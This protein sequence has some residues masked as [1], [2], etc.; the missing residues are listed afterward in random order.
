[1]LTSV[2]GEGGTGKVQ[3]AINADNATKA[4][5]ATNAT[6]LNGTSVDDST[7]STSVLWTAS[8]VQNTINNAVNAC[9]R[10]YYGASVPGNIPGSKEGDIYVMVD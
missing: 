7:T 1:M 6:K 5:S 10:T 8:K 9:H 4:T 3:H 2:Y